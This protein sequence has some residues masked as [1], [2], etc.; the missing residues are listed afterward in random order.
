MPLTHTP[1]TPVLAMPGPATPLITAPAQA[2]ESYQIAANPLDAKVYF[3]VSGEGLGHSSRAL[4]LARQFLPENIILGTYGYA[5]E[6]LQA[7]DLPCESLT[8]EIKLCG[9]EGTFDVGRTIVQN[10]AFALQF[11][12]LIQEEMDVMSRH[13][14]SLVVA[15]GRLTPVI[16]ASRLSLPCVVLTNQSAFYPFFEQDS[17]L[18]KWFGQSFDWVMT[19]C[20]CG[21][22]EILI[23]D[24][25]P[26]YT[27]C[28]HNLSQQPQ[29]KKRTRFIGP[30]VDFR[31]AEGL[32][33]SSPIDLE[34]RAFRHRVT[35][36]LGGHEYRRPL[37]EAVQAVARL[38]PD[39]AFDVLSPMRLN[40]H[41]TNVFVYPDVVQ[42]Y[43]FFAVADAVITQ[44]GHST[45]MELL[46]LGIPSVLVPDTKQIEQENNARRMVELGVAVSL[47]YHRLNPEQLRQALHNILSQP[48]YKANA[49]RFA[50]MAQRLQG[51]KQG[52]G[53]LSH[54][55]KRL[56]AY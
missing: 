27:V 36:S 12:Q 10:Q 42:S 2:L 35:V 13:R 33:Q 39:V 24:F 32:Q 21:A 15:D 22:E 45:A 17:P 54:Y 41:C 34:G 31:P 1:E 38:L 52:A 16:A 49:L 7:Y 53:V 40:V 19:L 51:A 43:P 28:L 47:E 50:E 14:A 20:M 25:P 9:A 29:V 55:A 5:L 48:L 3:S 56:S 44:A 4:A 26:P 23:P 30:L 46:S 18:L 8:Q 11:N 6:R 37:F